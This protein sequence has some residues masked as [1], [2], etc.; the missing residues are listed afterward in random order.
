MISPKQTLTVMIMLYKNTKPKFRPPKG[1][2]N[3]FD[4]VAGVLQRDKLETYLF[5]IC[6]LNVY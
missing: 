6:L 2:T 3:F 5:M 4:I 1:D